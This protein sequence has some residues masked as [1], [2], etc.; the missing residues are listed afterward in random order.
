M[1]KMQFYRVSDP[2]PAAASVELRH[3]QDHQNDHDP[4]V[5]VWRSV[6]NWLQGL[7]PNIGTEIPSADR[8]SH[9]LRDSLF[10][11]RPE[12]EVARVAA[13]YELAV[14][15]RSSGA[16]MGANATSNAAGAILEQGLLSELESVRRSSA[17]GLAMGGAQAVS[18]LLRLLLGPLGTSDDEH[19]GTITLAIH[20]LG[21]AS[22][23]CSGSENSS[24]SLDLLLPEIVSVLEG[25]ASRALG[26][27]EDYCRHLAREE[28]EKATAAL[29]GSRGGGVYSGKKAVDVRATEWRRTLATCAQASGIVGQASV[30][31]GDAASTLRLC[32]LVTQLAVGEEPGGEL[33]TALKASIVRENAAVA[34]LRICS[35]A[36][37]AAGAAGS[38]PTVVTPAMHS[39]WGD[40]SHGTTVSSTV[41]E[42]RRRLRSGHSSQA[43]VHQLLQ[44]FMDEFAWPA[45]AMEAQ[46][47]LA[48]LP[49]VFSSLQP[50]A[51]AI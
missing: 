21:Q 44:T 51:G 18:L 24:G 17:Y 16:A 9:T 22:T 35:V 42:A 36:A 19:Q 13:T 4:T 5:V 6:L 38:L 15:L 1:F 23:V 25:A 32:K 11:Q 27:I 12:D 47:Q 33:P 46:R 3:Q 48:T 31:R 49:A 34:L 40:D 37:G 26:A 7:S 28:L 29:D 2:T 20:A 30:R 39:G 10:S 8:I 41:E 45:A 14:A 50:P 43:H